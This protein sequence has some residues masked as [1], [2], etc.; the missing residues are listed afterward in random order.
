[1]VDRIKFAEMISRGKRVL[2]IGGQKMP[3]CDPGSRFAREYGRIER[4][5]GDYRIID[6]QRKPSVDYVLDF[7]ESVS[8]SELRS[9][10]DD[11]K[12]EV[13]LCMEILEHVNYHFELMNEMARAVC[14]HNSIVFIT[15]PNNGNWVFNSLGW[16]GDH[17]I[18]FFRD[19]ARKFIT[20]SDLGQHGVL[21][22]PCMQKYLWYWRIVLA[23]SFFQPFNWGFLI[24]P[25]GFDVDA[26]VGAFQKGFRS[27]ARHSC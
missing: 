15:I 17:S 23:V 12:P 18:A 6:Y 21:V 14:D 1:M 5:A 13:I 22:A 27:V 10:I 26:S 24:C 7:N 3:S 20:R 9:I 16:N 4:G 11:F 8:M 25:I 19:I 2:D